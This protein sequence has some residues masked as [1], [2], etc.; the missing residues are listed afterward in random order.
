MQLDSFKMCVGLIETG[1]FSRSGQLNHVTLSVISQQV[2]S[3]EQRYGQ[4]LV[5]RMLRACAA[6][7]DSLQLFQKVGSAGAEDEWLP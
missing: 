3:L 6:G 2:R 5:Y 1:L 7:G 4:R